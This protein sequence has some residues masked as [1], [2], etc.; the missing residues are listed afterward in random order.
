MSEVNLAINQTDF[1]AAGPIELTSTQQQ[2][3]K[4][5]NTSKSKKYPLG[6]WYLGAIYAAKNIHNPDRFSQAAQSLRELL[7]KLPRVFIESEVQESPAD[8]RGMRSRLYSRLCSDKKRYEGKWKGKT[9]NASLDKTIRGVDRYLE[10]NQLPTRKEQIHSVMSKLDPMHETLDQKIRHEKSERFHSLWKT[11][12]GLAHHNNDADETFFWEQLALVEKL[13]MD[14][15]APVTAQDQ[16]AIQTLI[17][18]PTPNENDFDALLELIKRRGSNYAFFFN[19]VDS[20]IWITP[21]AQNGFFKNPS[22]VEVLDDGRILTP[23]WWPIVYLQKVSVQAPNQVVEII[24]GLEKTDN[25]RILREIFSLACGLEDTELSLRLKPLIKK[26]IQSPYRWGE[27]ELIVNLL[28]KWGNTVGS[29]Q[30]AALEILQYVVAFQADPR[31]GEKRTLRKE[32]PKSYGATLSPAPRFRDWEYQQILEKGVRLLA[33]RVPYQV[34]RILIDAT[35][36]MIRLGSH[37]EI[38]DAGHVEDWSEIWCRRL[39]LSDRE[40]HGSDEILINILTYACEQ[41]FIKAP[42]SVEALDQTLRN[43]QWK[44]FKRLRQYLYALHPNDQTLPWIREIIINHGDY[45]KHEHN[46]EFQL[47]IRNSCEYFGTRLLNE[48]ERKSIID[49]ILSGP[50]KEDYQEWL[51]DQY[52]E[53]AYQKRQRYFHR[54]QLRPF[55]SLLDGESQKY[56]EELDSENAQ[57]PLTD[58]DYS[59]NRSAVGTV[60]YKSPKSTDELAQYS[61]DDLLTYINEWNG[62]HRDENNWFVEINIIALVNAFQSIFKDIIIPDEHRLAFW[63]ERRD[64]IARPAYVAAMLKAMLELV[65]ELKFD[66]LDQW[67]EFCNWILQ[68]PDADR[69]EGEPEPNDESRERPNW[70]SSRRTVVDF[71][72]VCLKEDVN[73]P[74]SA[75]SDLEKL[76]QKVCTQFDWRL[77]R[78][79]AVLLN[80]DDQITEAINNTRSRALESLINF[81]CWVRRCSSEDNVPEITEILNNR[82]KADADYALT[83]P[84]QALLGRHF[85][86]LSWFNQDWACDNKNRLFPQDN[87]PIWREAFGSFLLYTQPNKLTFDILRNDF[88]F[89]LDNLEVFASNKDSRRDTI[90]RLGQHLFCYYLWDFYPLIGEESLLARFYEKTTEDKERWAHLFDHVGRILRNSDKNLEANLIE[91]ISVYFDWRLEAKQPL[92]LNEFTFWLDAECL[93]PEWRLASYSKILELR[94][95]KKIG[96]S[97]EMDSLVKLLPDYNAKV[98][99]CFAKITDSLDQGSNVYISAEEAKPILRAGLASE[100]SQVREAAERARENLLRM[101]RFDFL[102]I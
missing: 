6:D 84:E 25:P 47:L 72:D 20:P 55:V 24:L 17:T 92:E 28:D 12:E 1:H 29:A 15:L 61:D 85:W 67:F 99:Q 90:D 10:L 21:L 45:A 71:I 37:Q 50:S 56:L 3:I 7:E 65:K 53:E 76:L 34:A 98:V 31:E 57:K 48:T 13:I 102:D 94:T 38:L 5:L 75:R 86:Y 4:I 68:H 35:T 58:E 49:F 83:K 40:H 41:V 88:D 89:A 44:V 11:F 95:T 59:P 87:I 82:L 62:Q 52:S 73:I 93:D 81:G 74:I 30:N 101:G 18:K 51:G 97:I 16:G 77:D 100:D 64:D 70:G 60:S 63:I 14:L 19:T 66:K 96:L 33:E 32:N 2:V 46:Y 80:R 23:L 27:D 36:N 79:Q 39:N 54:M 42:D 78:D 69:K 91:R 26:Y 9:V 22:K 43:Q 8:F